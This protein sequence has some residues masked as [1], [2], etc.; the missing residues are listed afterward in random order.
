MN[1]AGRVET[2]QNPHDRLHA[3]VISIKARL[4]IFFSL[5]PQ[6]TAGKAAS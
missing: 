1:A 6:E 2:A 5:A 4:N 3:F